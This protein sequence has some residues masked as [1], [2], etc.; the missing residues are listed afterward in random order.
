MWRSNCIF[1]FHIWVLHVTLQSKCT[2]G[3]LADSV[4]GFSM[5]FS[6]IGSHVSLFNVNVTWMN[7]CSSAFMRQILNRTCN[8]SIS[9]CRLLDAIF[10]SLCE[11]RTIVSSIKVHI[12]VYFLIGKSDVY[13][14]YNRRPNTLLCGTPELMS[15]FEYFS[16]RIVI[17]CL[18]EIYNFNNKYKLY[19]RNFFNFI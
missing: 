12:V 11:D 8:F 17:K 7:L 2:P 14:R 15:S 16:W 5:L 18:F 10:R 1:F 13:R 4:C 3:Y 6:F 19:G 9:F